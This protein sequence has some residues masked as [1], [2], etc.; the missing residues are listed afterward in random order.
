M[1]INE[2]WNEVLNYCN[3]HIFYTIKGLPFTLERKKSTYIY[4]CRNGEHLRPIAKNNME[5]ILN[6]PNE[7]FLIYSKEMQ[8]ASYAL[9]VFHE[10]TN[11]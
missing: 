3:G 9:A 2:L 7:N 8:C 11:K 4:A 5:F 10:L 6:N 1:N